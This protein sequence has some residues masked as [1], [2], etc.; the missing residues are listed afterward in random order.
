MDSQGNTPERTG[1][2]KHLVEDPKKVSSDSPLTEEELK[3]EVDGL[4]GRFAETN[5]DENLAEGIKGKDPEW[6]GGPTGEEEGDEYKDLEE[7][8]KTK[9]SP[10]EENLED[11]KNQEVGGGSDLAEEAISGLPHPPTEKKE[12]EEVNNLEKTMSERN[13]V[14]GEK[15]AKLQQQ[16]EEEKRVSSTVPENTESEQPKFHTSI[17]PAT[18]KEAYEEQ[19]DRIAYRQLLEDKL[20]AKPA[21]KRTAAMNRAIKEAKKAEEKREAFKQNR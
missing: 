7:F 18:S 6:V 2:L 5:T 17:S 4:N 10:L 13:E 14:A 16:A 1:M 12:K 9:K 8:L 11:G 15:I 21:E 19:R 20:N 3:P